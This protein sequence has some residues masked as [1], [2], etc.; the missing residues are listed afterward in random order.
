MPS[1]IARDLSVDGTGDLLVVGGDLVM[2]Y[3]IDGIAQDIKA[4]LLLFQGE[5][6]LAPDQGIPYFG[7][8]LVKNPNLAVIRGIF[9]RAIK[10][11]LGVVDVLSIQLK[12]VGPNRQLQITHSTQTNSGII[13]QTVLLPGGS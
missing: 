12:F 2:T 3:D 8:V 13:D 10:G 4:T 6:F 9:R 1:T 7:S 5:W 11:V